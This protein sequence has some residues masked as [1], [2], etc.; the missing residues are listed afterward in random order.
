MPILSPS[1]LV[2]QQGKAT[3]VTAIWRSLLLPPSGPG[4]RSGSSNKK[5]LPPQQ[6]QHHHHQQQ[7]RPRTGKGVS[8]SPLYILVALTRHARGDDYLVALAQAVDDLMQNPGVSP[9]R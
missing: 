2:P 5:I 8:P 7:T 9:G 3:D 4:G 1:S 6:H